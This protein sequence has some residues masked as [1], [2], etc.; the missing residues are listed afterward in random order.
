LAP[1]A[2]LLQLL[3]AGTLSLLLFLAF[4]QRIGLVQ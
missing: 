3:L 4:A 2:F 1:T